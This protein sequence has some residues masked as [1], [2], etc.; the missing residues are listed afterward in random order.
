MNDGDLDSNSVVVSINIMTPKP[1]NIS[2]CPVDRMQS[3]PNESCGTNVTWTS[4]VVLNNAAGVTITSTHEPGE[5]FSVG[6]TA[7]EYSA[8]DALGNIDTCSFDI[9]ISPEK[10]PVISNCPEDITVLN[11]PGRAGAIVLWTPPS[12][13]QVCPELTVNSSHQ[14]G[15]F[16][17]LGMTTVEYVVLGSSGST[18]RCSF[19]INVNFKLELEAGWN[20]ISLPKRPMLTVED[21]F[22][23]SIAGRLWKWNS[24]GYKTTNTI[25]PKIG[26]WLYSVRDKSIVISN[27]NEASFNNEI[28]IY[29]GWNFMG[30]QGMLHNP[31]NDLI[32]VMIWYWHE[33]K[34]HKVQGTNGYLETGKGYWIHGS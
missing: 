14:P 21:L 15:D 34:F 22:G 23:D 24:E 3:V 13:V 6:I 10:D 9:N 20:S 27:F 1:W 18:T 29:S 28:E 16:F 12:I 11:D 19:T 26:Y 7:V 31:Y 17:P 4:P 5:I 25:E 8:E 33:G 2:N 30:T 32:N